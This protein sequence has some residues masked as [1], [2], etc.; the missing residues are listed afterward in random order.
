MRSLPRRMP[1]KPEPG[2]AGETAAQGGR[3]NRGPGGRGE[4]GPWEAGKTGARAKGVRGL[5]P[6]SFCSGCGG[7][8]PTNLPHPISGG[9]VRAGIVARW[10]AVP[11]G[12]PVRSTG[13]RVSTGRRDKLDRTFGW[14]HIRQTGKHCAYVQPQG[15]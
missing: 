2:E 6:D 15:W 5:A 13:P 12:L 11:P 3:G 8:A 4:P 10:R 14:H 9:C 1:G 7:E